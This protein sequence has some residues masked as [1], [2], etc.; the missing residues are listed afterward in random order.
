MGFVKGKKVVPLMVITGLLIAGGSQSIDA[1]QGHRFMVKESTNK[2][3]SISQ[4][5]TEEQA[6]E[7]TI[8]LFEKY[9]DEKIDTENL[10]EDTRLFKKLDKHNF[11]GKDYWQI[12]WS[13]FD[14]NKPR[15]TK[16]MTDEEINQLNKDSI[17]ATSYAA[18][19]EEST[20]EIIEIG[21]I[22]GHRDGGFTIDELR[23]KEI[24][25]EEAK[26]IALDYIEKNRPVKNIKDL[27]FLGEIRI[28]PELCA[29][30]YKY[31]DDKVIQIH[32]DSLSKKVSGF[33]YED[34]E[35]VKKGIE[36]NKNYKTDGGIG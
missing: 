30:A 2:T 4:K 19:L 5:L 20:G 13:T 12:S 35:K 8:K 18:L 21:K 10:F 26:N 16:G 14:Y 27:E 34:E 17:H 36:I 25:T 6:K 3:M 23:K 32:V 24:G 11:E 7:K 22:D 28:T 9:F 29:I 15:D 31:D 33:R 1:I